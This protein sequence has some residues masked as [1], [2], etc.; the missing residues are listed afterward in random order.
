MS[1]E[2]FHLESLRLARKKR[3]QTAQHFVGALI[4]IVAAAKHVGEHGHLT[5][6][7]VLEIAAGA[8]L[9]GT[10]LR[11]RVRKTHSR[12]GWVEIGGAAMMFVEALRNLETP[13]TTAFRIASFLPPL[14]LLLFG[15]FE[16]QVHASVYVRA[17]EERL[18]LRRRLLFARHFRWSD[19]SGFRVKEDQIELLRANGRSARLNL[20]GMRNA[21]AAQAWVV[22]Q[23]E[24]RGVERLT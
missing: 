15:I 20:G 6:L 19:L 14:V 1:E 5:L 13:H 11:D 22:A 4:M 16:Q 3:M 21:D 7:P 10:V 18:T 23:L 9:V 8:L 17:G 12:V 24:R 2:T